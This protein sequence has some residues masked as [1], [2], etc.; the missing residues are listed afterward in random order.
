MSNF[1][2][3]TSSFIE[4][5]KSGNNNILVA[6]RTRPLNSKELNV[7][8]FEIVRVLDQKVVVLLDPGNEFQYDDVFR[9]NRNKETQFAF[10]FAFDKFTDQNTVY[11][12][13]S[14]FVVPAVMDGYNAT[15]FSYGATGAG[16]TH[17]MVGTNE[18]PGI[19]IKCLNE[20]F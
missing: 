18:H 1:T 7:S 2:H 3:E 14:S 11:E 5:L 13:S 17:T 20:L 10:D 12:K 9:K 6:V 19:M 16:K 15:I 4:E 8:D